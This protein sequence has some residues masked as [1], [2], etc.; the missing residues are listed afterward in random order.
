MTNIDWLAKYPMHRLCF[1][2]SAPSSNQEGGKGGRMAPRPEALIVKEKGSVV[3][4]DPSCEQVLKE[5]RKHLVEILNILDN[6][7]CETSGAAWSFR[8]ARAHAL[9]L[10]DHLS[11]I[12]ESP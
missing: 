2:E 6:P 4:D 7:A 11:R 8:L 9:T 10:L 12:E 5:A 1:C 3:L